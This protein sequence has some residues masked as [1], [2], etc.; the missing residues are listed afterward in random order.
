VVWSS[1]SEKKMTLVKKF[2]ITT[3]VALV[4]LWPLSCVD[5][6][7]QFTVTSV[8][9][10]NTIACQGCGIIFRVRLVG[11]DAP[12]KGTKK[13]PEQPYAEKARKY[14]E[15]LIL[16]KQVSIKQ[17]GIDRQNFLLA[18]VYLENS[19]GLFSSKRQNI[20]LEMIK[21]GFAEVAPVRSGLNMGP[22]KKAQKTSKKRKLNIWS[23]EDYVSPQEWR[24][25]R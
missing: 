7:N 1:R 25:M 11:I 13:R 2:F 10:G 21:Q 3:L 18:I 8:Y 15:D 14:L 20:N 17:I 4:L 23:Q 24:K 12:E 19:R 22:Y 9:D 5:A 6:D 16:G